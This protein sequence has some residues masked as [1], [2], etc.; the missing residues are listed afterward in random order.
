MPVPDDIL[1][2]DTSAYL[3]RSF[4][5]YAVACYW[6]GDYAECAKVC[7]Q[8]LKTGVL[9]PDQVERVAENLTLA[10]RKLRALTPS[11]GPSS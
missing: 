9:P 4:D 10:R 1:F 5:E 6:T 11:N 2:I 8:L 3:W 7:G